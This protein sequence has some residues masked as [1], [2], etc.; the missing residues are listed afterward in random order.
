MCTRGGRYGNVRTGPAHVMLPRCRR[1]G[2]AL[3]EQDERGGS[4]VSHL[5][6]GSAPLR[7][8]KGMCTT[9]WLPIPTVLEPLPMAFQISTL[10]LP[11]TRLPWLPVEVMSPLLCV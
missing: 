6:R 3:G 7:Q 2:A 9:D 1:H 8:P 11:F 10:T 4:P 5:R